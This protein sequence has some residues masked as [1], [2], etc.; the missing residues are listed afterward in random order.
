[1]DRRFFVDTDFYKI[2]YADEK[3]ASFDKLNTTE[4][5]LLSNYN[6]NG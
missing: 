5:H 2:V 3:I 4:T 6:L 1:M